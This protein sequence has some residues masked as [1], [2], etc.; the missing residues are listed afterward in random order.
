VRR[1]LTLRAVRQLPF[2]VEPVVED[3]VDRFELRLTT[4][5]SFERESASRSA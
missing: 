5:A 2:S 3:V 4:A 1:R